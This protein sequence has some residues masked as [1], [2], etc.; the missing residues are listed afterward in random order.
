MPV[1]EEAAHCVRRIEY[2]NEKS[3]N[4]TIAFKI[5]YS[6][7]TVVAQNGNSGTEEEEEDDSEDMN[8]RGTNKRSQ[9]LSSKQLMSLLA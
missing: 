3:E 6:G 8:I 2:S 5:I 1:S 9:K 7:R 4:K